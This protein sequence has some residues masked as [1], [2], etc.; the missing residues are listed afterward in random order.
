MFIEMS[1][2][3]EIS[4]FGGAE[5]HTHSHEEVAFRSSER[6]W[7]VSVY[8]YKHLTPNGVKPCFA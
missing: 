7:E 5:I 2:H 3:R 4:P 6:R 1:N 8:V